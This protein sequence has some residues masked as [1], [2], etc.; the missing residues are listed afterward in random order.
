MSALVG[1]SPRVE[2]SHPLI[3]WQI[4]GDDVRA[5]L[6]AL[7]SYLEEPNLVTSALSPH[8]Q[9]SP[10]AWLFPSAASVVR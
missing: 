5:A 8:G 2:D 6:P 3:E 10:T 7:P 4:A 9:K 1:R